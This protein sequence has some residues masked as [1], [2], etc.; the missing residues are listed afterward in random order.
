MNDLPDLT[1]ILQHQLQASLIEELSGM[2]GVEEDQI[3]QLT[4]PRGLVLNSFE[5]LLTHSHPPV[6]L[7]V[8]TKEFAQQK[9]DGPL[10]TLPKDVARVLYFACIG[11]ALLHAR[12]RISQL[13]FD[14]MRSGFEWCLQRRWLKPELRDLLEQ[15]VRFCD[16][17]GD[18]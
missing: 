9:L 12:T 10:S 6:Q 7:L 8:L 15:A 2:E 13:G 5:D 1:A 18:Q 17:G 16:Q 4:G 11:S 3:R 14:Q